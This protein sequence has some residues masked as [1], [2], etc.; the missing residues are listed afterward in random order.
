MAGN[1]MPTLLANSVSSQPQEPVADRE[2]ERRLIEAAKH[3]PQALSQLYRQ[4]Y[5]AISKHIARRVGRPAIAEDLVA[6]VFLAMVRYLP[7][8]RVGTTPFRAWLFRMATNR[9]NRWAR[10]QR[11]RACRQLHD[12]PGP[13]KPDNCVQRA[14]YVRSALL[15]LPL[16]LQSVLSLYYL[17]EMSI[18]DIAL[19]LGCAEGTVKSRLSRGREMLRATL[20][21]NEG[22][23]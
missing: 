13:A 22:D 10:W 9:V 8:Y 19:A 15:A 16:R 4:H 6:D 3:D 1:G 5:D 21:E 14:E 17:D 20:A 18:H 2:A 23:S 11:R 7:R 12:V